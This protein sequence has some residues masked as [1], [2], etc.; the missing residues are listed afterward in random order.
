MMK[1]DKYAFG[2]LKAIYRIIHGSKEKSTLICKII[3]TVYSGNKQ[4]E[5][6]TLTLYIDKTKLEIY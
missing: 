1:K 4:K 2:N 5:I 6:H 3:K